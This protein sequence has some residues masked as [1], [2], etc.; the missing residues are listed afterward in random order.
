MTTPT[1]SLS[2]LS[3]GGG[4]YGI[5][6]SAADFSPSLPT[7]LRISDI[8]DDGT[9]DFAGLKS[10]DDP[11]SDRYK[12]KPDDIV[13][14]R[15]GASTGRNYFYDG[16]DGELVYAGFL[17]KFSIDPSKVNPLFIKYYCRSQQ[18]NDWVNSFNSGSTRGNIN[19]QTLSNMPIP[20]LPREQQDLI[21]E[22]LSSIDAKIALNKQINHHLEQMAQ[23][24]YKSWF[25][26]F[27]PWGGAM[28]DGWE[29]GALRDI[30]EFSDT[31]IAVSALT[32]DSYISTENM[33]TNKGGFTRAAGLP[34]IA[35]TTAF[36]FGDT[37]V[38]NIRPYFRKIVYCDFGGGC[39]TDVLCFRPKQSIFAQYIFSTLFSDRFFDYMVAG[40]KGTKMPRGDKRQIMDYPVAI[41][42]DD[43]L[44]K[45]N[46]FATAL[47]DKKLLLSD[48]SDRLAETRDVL[49]PKLMSGEISVAGLGG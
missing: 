9:L 15:T 47:I 38:S 42:A 33:L 27:D 41:P 7:Y 13:F 14:A 30:C 32:L 28:P 17:I 29:I 21:A 48:E 49:L 6:A 37:L 11:R 44:A 34:T 43:I 39:S 19:A 5:A 31:R 20:A 16:T 45:F 46:T 40:S 36:K 4:T 12:L 2:S 1:V 8:N 3:K 23:A 25:V 35:Q 10:V 18:Y 24:I 26:D 22:T